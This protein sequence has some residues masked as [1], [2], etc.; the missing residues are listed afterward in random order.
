M[1]LN[2]RGMERGDVFNRNVMRDPNFR[3]WCY[4]GLLESCKLGAQNTQNL[5][6]QPVIRVVSFN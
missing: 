2:S 1:A 3:V 4:L 6:R 5:V